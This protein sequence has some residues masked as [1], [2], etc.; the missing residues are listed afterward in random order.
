MCS[1]GHYEHAINQEIG[2]ARPEIPAARRSAVPIGS[3]E[4]E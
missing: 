1:T 3:A 2:G 4:G